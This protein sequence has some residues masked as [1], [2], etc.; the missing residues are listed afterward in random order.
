MF[1]KF[2]QNNNLMTDF[3]YRIFIFYIFDILTNIIVNN[4]M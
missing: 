3:I 4:R 1:G 2:K